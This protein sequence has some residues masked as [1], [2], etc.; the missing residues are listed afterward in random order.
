M[1][2]NKWTSVVTVASLLL[3]LN[4]RSARPFGNVRVENLPPELERDGATKPGGLPGA[5]HGWPDFE[6]VR[7]S[8]GLERSGSGN[9]R[10]RRHV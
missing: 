1:R 5:A 6:D 9:A 2:V 7:D 3:P 4:L 10:P 8:L